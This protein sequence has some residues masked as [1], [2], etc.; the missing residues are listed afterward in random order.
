MQRARRVHALAA[1]GSVDALRNAAACGWI[2]PPGAPGERR[3]HANAGNAS[4]ETR[5]V[6][7]SGA[8]DP[9]VAR[10]FGYVHE[11]VNLGLAVRPAETIDP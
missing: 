7:R 9:V 8:V 11:I 10:R 4:V 3:L 1:R 5:R 2:R 6:V